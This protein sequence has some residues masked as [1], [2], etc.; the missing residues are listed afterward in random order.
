MKNLCRSRTRH[1]V[2]FSN[3]NKISWKNTNKLNMFKQMCL[4]CFWS[5]SL[6]ALLFST[7][8][9]H[10]F[11]VHFDVK[12]KKIHSICT[13]SRNDVDV[14]LYR[15]LFPF[16]ATAVV[17]FCSVR[18]DY[19]INR[20]MLVSCLNLIIHLYLCR[21]SINFFHID[22]WSHRSSFFSRFDWLL[23]KHCLRFVINHTIHVIPFNSIRFL[24]A[25]A[26]RAIEKTSSALCHRIHSNIVSNRVVSSSQLVVSN[27]NEHFET[28]G[29]NGSSSAIIIEL[30]IIRHS[31]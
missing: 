21:I 24:S 10:W 17:T 7:H 13:R 22:H 19:Q 5:R 30:L 4:C 1:L 23:L 8:Q 18:M 11:G 25:L 3:E 29:I 2:W 12:W 20:Y 9:H 31:P 27:Y 6:S 28:I 26:L 14:F 16:N 15:L